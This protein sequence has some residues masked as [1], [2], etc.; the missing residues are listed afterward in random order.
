[1][2]KIFVKM[3]SADVQVDSI[4]PDGGNPTNWTSSSNDEFRSSLN[5]VLSNV[6][7]INHLSMVPQFGVDIFLDFII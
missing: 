3:P 2:V 1:M 4:E 5:L 7:W 6:T